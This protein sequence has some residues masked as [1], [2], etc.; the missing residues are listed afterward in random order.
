[1]TIQADTIELDR[2]RVLVR[3]WPAI[4]AALAAGVA[5]DLLAWG[6]PGGP[7]LSVALVSVVLAITV[8]MRIHGPV[9]TPAA[10][11]L[12][13]AAVMAGVPAIRASLALIGLSVFAWAVLVAVAV[14]QGRDRSGRPWVMARYLRAGF[15]WMFAAAEPVRMAFAEL[16]GVRASSSATARRAL[17]LVRG[18]ALSWVVLV[19]FTVL[20]S[21]ADPI[22]GGIVAETLDVDLS[23]DR[24]I[25]FA[26]VAG[27]AAWLVLGLSRRAVGTAV[28]RTE[29]RPSSFGATEALAVVGSLNL[30][31]AG[32][33][34]VQFTY[35]FD[36]RV[37]RVDIGYAQYARQGFFELVFAA[38]CV[39]SLILSVDWIVARRVRTLDLLHLGLIVQTLVM[40]WSA[41][42]R[43]L[44]YTAEF[45]LSELR[46]YTTA[47]MAWI[48][49]LMVL[50]AVTVLRSR[51]DSFAFGAFVTGLVAIVA[52]VAL[53]PDGFIAQTN[54]ARS[55]SEHAVDVAYL[56]TLSADAVP[57]M[58]AAVDAAAP[59][60]R[61]ALVASLESI[62]AELQ[63]RAD[64]WG[65][66]SWSFAHH[67]ALESIP[68]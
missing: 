2:P 1:M 36:G 5:V 13:A 48:A 60:T 37:G 45:G 12:G 11:L 47:F 29:F 46:V 40:T 10:R 9:S 67:R 25:R 59:D 55:D 3:P 63:T 42:V 49:V 27:G 17:P 8:T 7:G 35:L 6:R 56:G 20:L 66:R 62:R 34:A 50:A 19:F 53:N 33:L 26:A 44:A 57:A 4:A 14:A 65:W 68:G 54:L 28:L 24:V 41:L 16:E 38:A 58:A 18:L 61:Q 39:L 64:T 32:F 43:M 52:L 51:R 31:F 30:L 23:P 22:F 15:E 21:A